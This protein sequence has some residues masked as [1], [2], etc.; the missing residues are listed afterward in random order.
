MTGNKQPV[1]LRRL[2]RHWFTFDSAATRAFP[3]SLF[4]KIEAVIAKV[5]SSHHCEIALAVEASLKTA[6]IRAGLT[7]RARAQ[8]LFGTLGVWDT[9]HNTGVLLYVLIADRSVELVTDRGVKARIPDST[10]QPLIAELTAA[11]KSGE[12]Q[13]STLQFLN[14]LSQQLDSTFSESLAT[15]VVSKPSNPDEVPNRPRYI[16]GDS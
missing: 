12:Y 7:P 15:N 3:P 10:W 11:Y 14:L 1:G 6:E 9:E 2:L 4:N 16:R 13:Q 8:R 5:E